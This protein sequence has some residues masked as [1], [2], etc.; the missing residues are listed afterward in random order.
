MEIYILEDR[1]MLLWLPQ[2]HKPY[3]PLLFV[4]FGTFASNNPRQW[5]FTTKKSMKAAFDNNKNSL[6][7]HVNVEFIKWFHRC[8]CTLSNAI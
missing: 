2:A 5:W 3:H 8:Y 1:F 4:A 6:L 7:G